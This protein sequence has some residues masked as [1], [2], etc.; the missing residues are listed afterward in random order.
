MG[1]D[2]IYDQLSSKDVLDCA[3]M[4][5]NNLI[6]EDQNNLNALC[7][8]IVDMILKMSM[9]RESYDNVTCLIF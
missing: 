2:G 3:W 7:G 8:K 6:D 9:V 4:V 5:L 1:C